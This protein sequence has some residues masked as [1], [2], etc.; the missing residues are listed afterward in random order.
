MSNRPAPQE[1]LPEF[2]LSF[3]EIHAVVDAFYRQVAVDPLLRVPFASVH[4]W[5]EHIERMTHFW[6]TRLGGSPYLETRYNPVAKHFEAG[7]NA[8]FLERWLGLFEET[9]KK[10]LSDDKA[11][12]WHA[13]AT[14]MG[15]ALSAKNEY[16]RQ[17]V[18]ANGSDL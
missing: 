11:Q 16:L 13:L 17:K 12:L 4:D 8:Q 9:L 5:P 6:W 7:F 15:A 1:I 18:A 10:T 3:G 14:R 2:G